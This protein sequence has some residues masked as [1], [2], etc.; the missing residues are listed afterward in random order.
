MFKK[1]RKIL[2]APRV[3]YQPLIE[4]R[5]FKDAFLHNL[6][7]YQ[8]V[9]PKL[10]IAPVLK[11]NAYGHGLIQVAQILDNQN[12]PFFM[13][14][15]FYE[16]LT[17][18]QEGIKTKI[19]ILGFLTE[20]HIQNNLSDCSLGINSL[21]VLRRISQ[22]LTSP[23]NFHLKIDTGMHR[24][25]ILIEEIDEAIMLV[26]QNSK[27]VLEGL[28]TH[29]ADAENDDHDFTDKQ[30]VRWNNAVKIFRQ[31]FP[32][33]KYF[34]AANTAGI[35]YS[36]SIDANVAR[37]GLGLYQSTLEMRSSISLVK[38]IHPGEKVGYGLTFEASKP[39]K[40]ASVPVGYFEGVDRRLSNLGSFKLGEAYCPILGKVSM[41][42]TTIDVSD[43]NGVKL[44]EEVVVISANRGDKNSVANMAKLCGCTEYE[45]LVH[46]P[47]SLRRII[48]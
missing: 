48:V 2:T 20:D 34:H 29:F 6:R 32:S 31:K 39:I 18:R 28:C 36:K 21:E 45:I 7:E 15:S 10:Q 47:Q 44:G 4:I 41:N 13:V 42:M 46:I 17:L 12:L 23:K 33:I 3:S 14:D 43:V 9:Y 27:I 19:L 37:I 26:K 16:A 35:G 8:R 5:I 30:I 22:N 38:N 11:S 24:Q 40:I 1:I 25:G